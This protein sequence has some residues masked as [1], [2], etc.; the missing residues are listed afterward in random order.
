VYAGTTGR[1]LPPFRNGHDAV[2]ADVLRHGARNRRDG[3]IAHDA[4]GDICSSHGAH[5][6]DDLGRQVAGAPFSYPA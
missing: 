4:K 3:P 2:K 6:A 5:G 1:L